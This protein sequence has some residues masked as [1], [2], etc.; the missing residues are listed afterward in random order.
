ML[1]FMDG[2]DSYATADI[3]KK[4]TTSAGSA[5]IG[6]AAGRRSSGA[7]VSAGTGNVTKSLAAGASFVMG[8]AVSVSSV[9]AS[10]RALFQL[11]DAATLQCDL[12]IN[13]DLTLSVTRNGTALTNGTSVSALATGAFYYIEWKVTIADSIGAS[14]CVVKVNGATWITVATG[15]DTKNTANASANAVILGP[16]SSVTGT[17]TIDDF[18]ICDQSGSAPQNDF[19]GDCRIDTLLPNADGSNSAWTPSTGSSHYQLVDEATPNT[20]D[21]VES[22]TVGQKDTWNFQDLAAVTGTIFGIQVNT[23]ALKSDAGVRSI[24]N[25]IK[26]GATN[27]DGATVA[28][29]TSQLYQSDIWY[30]DPATSAAWTEANINSLEAGVKVIA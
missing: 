26:S 3:N 15:Q 13:T 11:T 4:W 25:T 18:Y 2:F 16:S 1:L 28:L 8:C 19:L 14:S 6:A 29:S 30:Q 23:A 20:S 7:L 9:S 12:R 10:A 5:A 27:A 17:W 21:Y 24:A 22:N